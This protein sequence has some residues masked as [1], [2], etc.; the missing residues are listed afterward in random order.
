LFDHSD[1]FLKPLSTLQRQYEALRAF[2][3]DKLSAREVSSNFGFT[4]FYFNKLCCLFH[5]S[6]TKGQIPVFFAQ[7]RPGPRENPQKPKIK[8]RIVELRRKNYSI[9]NIKAILNSQGISIGLSQIDR[10]LKAEGFSRLP[11]RNK[12]E[13]KKI[14][15]PKK[16]ESPK[17]ERLDFNQLPQKNFTNC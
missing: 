7:N 2:Y 3:V 11:R 9:L 12:G 5:R 4:Q 15:E 10:L 13:R 8:E 14:E 6:L 16:F 17:V 1:F